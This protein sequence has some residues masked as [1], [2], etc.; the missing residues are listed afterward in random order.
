MLTIMMKNDEDADNYVRVLSDYTFILQL[1]SVLE[2]RGIKVIYVRNLDGF[3]AML[4]D[5]RSML[6]W[7]DWYLI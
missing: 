4:R 3:R 6:W 1:D 5:Y 7:G 2:K